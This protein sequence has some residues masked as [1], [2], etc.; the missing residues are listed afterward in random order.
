MSEVI[1]TPWKPTP[2]VEAEDVA[3]VPNPGV[4]EAEVVPRDSEIPE[5]IARRM[6]MK[7]SDIMQL[8]D[9][10][11]F[12]GCKNIMLGKLL[13]AHTQ[14][15]RERIEGCLRET[16]EGLARLQ[17]ADDRVT[18]AVVR[19]SKRLMGESSR[20]EAEKATKRTAI[21]SSQVLCGID[22]QC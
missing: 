13:Q 16:E 20:D 10:D 11:G 22:P 19:E 12:L 21:G 9:T 15:C 6:Y 5:S 8:N 2:N 18:E 14:A 1:G 7:R 3:R 4:A 17:R